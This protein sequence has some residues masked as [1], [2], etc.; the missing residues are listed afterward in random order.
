MFIYLLYVLRGESSV[1]SELLLNLHN[2]SLGA[3]NT[4][5]NKASN[6]YFQNKLSCTKLQ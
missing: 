6:N 1:N 2:G 3:I 4:V 5:T